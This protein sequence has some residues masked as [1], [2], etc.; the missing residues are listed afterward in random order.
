MIAIGSGTR[1]ALMNAGF[2]RVL[3]PDTF[4][5]E[6]LLTMPLLQTVAHQPIWICCGKDPRPVLHETLLSRGAKVELVICYQRR[7]P[8]IN[9]DEMLNQLKKSHCNVFIFTSPE[10]LTNFAN[11]IALSKQ[12][13]LL[14]IPIII[15]SEKMQRQATRYQFKNIILASN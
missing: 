10:S 14:E 15:I 13:W 5:T 8:I 11:M 2:H 12:S 1:D 6:G 9:T 4:D 3:L 7:C